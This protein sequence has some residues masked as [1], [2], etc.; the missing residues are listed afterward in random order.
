[1][2]ER[3][4]SS[5]LEVYKVEPAVH[6]N[7]KG[8]FTQRE[9]DRLSGVVAVGSLPSMMQPELMKGRGGERINRRQLSLTKLQYEGYVS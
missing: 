5:G 4:K 9:R 6:D 3:K 1:M 7:K 8:K 2:R